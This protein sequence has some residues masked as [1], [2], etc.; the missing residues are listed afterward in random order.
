CDRDFAL[1]DMNYQ[2]VDLIGDFAADGW[3]KGEPM[4]LD[5]GTWRTTAGMPWDTPVEYKFRINGGEGYI[6]DP[7]NPDQVEDGF[8][9]FNSVLDGQTCEEWECVSGNIG[10]FD[11]RDSIIY[12]VFVDRFYNGDLSNDGPIGVETPADWQGGDWA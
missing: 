10:D 4:I 2:S 9:G 7:N 12:F 5:A 6:P 11:W 3:S 8:G 1:A